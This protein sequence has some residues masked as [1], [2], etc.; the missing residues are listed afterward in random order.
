[1]TI[2]SRPELTAEQRENYVQSE[3]EATVTGGGRIVA[4]LRDKDLI[5]HEREQQIAQYVFADLI[6]RGEFL[7]ETTDEGF[8]PRCYYRSQTGGLF[9]LCNA[10][11]MKEL[12]RAYGL[13]S[14]KQLTDIVANHVLA[15][16]IKN[17]RKVNIHTGVRF[18]PIEVEIRVALSTTDT[19][20]IRIN[21]AEIVENGTDGVLMLPSGQP[22]SPDLAAIMDCKLGL[23]VA[24]GS[25]MHDTF[26]ANYADEPLTQA[27]HLQVV[28]AYILQL[29]FQ[30]PHSNKPLLVL[31]AES[32]AG[33][34]TLAT[35]IGSTIQGA[36]FEVND[37][38]DR[39][40]DLE[41]LLTSKTLV[42]LDN[43]DKPALVRKYE[44]LICQT[45]SGGAIA[46]R[47]L[48]TTLDPM[49]FP[50]TASLI[51]TSI[52]L[53]WMVSTIARRSLMV[54]L[55]PRFL[56]GREED[57]SS[58]SAK[59]LTVRDALMSE[60]MG[61]CR[62]ILIAMRAQAEYKPSRILQLHDF[63]GFILRA[64]VHEGWHDGAV[65]LIRKIDSAQKGE[66]AANNPI[67]IA[68][69]LYI[70]KDIEHT[71]RIPASILA[72]R[73]NV[74]A[75]VGGIDLKPIAG[76]YGMRGI[77]NQQFS[78]LA[79]AYGL[80]KEIDPHTK[81]NVYWFEPSVEVRGRCAKHL[82]L[83]CKWVAVEEGTFV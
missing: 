63:A 34:T 29:F 77:I 79:K 10:P 49:Q 40:D 6:R 38:P 20:V 23:K 83:A 39:K 24:P 78:S 5:Q 8:S 26:A 59:V 36:R 61:R 81:T 60:I 62:N 45:C 72:K 27:E 21:Y 64:A 68:I 4:I 51:C 3:S 71:Q 14:P 19:L 74:A 53:S 67:L 47:V 41:A 76:A 50:L 44:S 73:L 37:L 1:M 66:A 2:T 16:A 82:S 52:D 65:T 80:H 13:L 18:D 75:E 30:Q 15:S 7:C 55:S 35:K 28:C 31:D 43:L 25:L 32:G 57:D 58:I 69:E 42:V 46:K 48:H 54:S 22:F 12:M 17:G 11:K 70:G 56:D 33:K 9:D